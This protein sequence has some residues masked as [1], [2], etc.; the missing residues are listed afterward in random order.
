MARVLGR[1][2]SKRPKYNNQAGIE[3]SHRVILQVPDNPFSP[4]DLTDPAFL[5]YLPGANRD[6]IVNRIDFQ[7]QNHVTRTILKISKKWT[8]FAP[9]IFPIALPNTRIRQQDG[10]LPTL[11]CAG[12]LLIST[13]HQSAHPGL[14]KMCASQVE[15]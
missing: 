12:G 7:P 11:L 5:P 14:V 6:F 8:A 9:Q 4:L 13:S 10:N 1:I 3:E 15:I 2:N